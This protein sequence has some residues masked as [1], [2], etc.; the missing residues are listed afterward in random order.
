MFVT[1]HLK[2]NGM[3]Y[4][5]LIGF[6]AASDTG[7]FVTVFTS[8]LT[9]TLLI[10]LTAVSLPNPI[11]LRPILTL[12]LHLLLPLA[13]V[14]FHSRLTPTFCLPYTSIS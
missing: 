11:S 4:V 9:R 5:M 1:E 14:L 10:Q 2:H 3:I 12:L 7:R 6:A 13:C 8:A